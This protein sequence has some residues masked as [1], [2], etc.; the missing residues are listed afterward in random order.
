MR[1]TYALIAVLAS[2]VLAGSAGAQKRDVDMDIAAPDGVKLKATYHS[3]GKPGPGML[4]LHQCN[5]DRKSWTKLATALVERGVHV[6]AI[7][8]RSYGESGGPRGD[9]Q[10]L[11]PMLQEKWPGD[12]D[13][14]FAT[15]LT[16]PGVDG[17]RV[18]AGGA[19][20]G[21]NNSIQLAR[22]SG[23]VKALMLLSGGTNEDGQNYLAS[24]ADTPIFAATSQE[25]TRNVE[26]LRKVVG[27]SKSPASQ[28]KILTNAGHGV[29][30]FAADATLL[31]AIADW[32]ANALK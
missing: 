24:A 11:R 4:L 31:P 14:A 23:K 7:D 32:L 30:M 8:Y 15:L 9:W 25:E 19:S 10:Q 22:R 17:S 26:V 13:A 1:K 28:V 5:M 18:G 12:V 21:V 2:L 27:G 16:Q 6:L 29:E 3:P 20:C